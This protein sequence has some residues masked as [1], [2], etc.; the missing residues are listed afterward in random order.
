M[1]AWAVAAGGA[2]RL[3]E[4]R[5]PCRDRMEQGPEVRGR[6]PAA[7]RARA[8]VDPSLTTSARAA[9]VVVR[10]AT[11]AVQDKERARATVPVV[12]TAHNAERRKSCQ[13][14]IVQDRWERDR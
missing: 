5:K 1:A 11:A 4:R 7:A 14:E 6:A 3:Q 10:R 12:G 8:R 13:E 2:D 9:D